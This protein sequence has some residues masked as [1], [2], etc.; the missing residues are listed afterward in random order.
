MNLLDVVPTVLDWFQLSYPRYSIFRKTPQTTLA[1]NS[2]MPLVQSG[3]SN[4]HSFD[5]TFAS[6]SLHEITMY[7]PMRVV[8]TQSHKLIQNINYLMPF[9]IDQDLYVSRTF[10]NMMKRTSSGQTL[11]WYKT[12]HSYYY[13]PQW[14]LFDLKTDPHEL[15]N[16]Y[17]MPAYENITIDLMQKLR[18]WQ[19]V[20]ADPWICAPDGVLENKGR[21]RHSPTCLP[22]Y[23][24][25]AVPSHD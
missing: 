16:L 24:G 1:G 17:G 2:L 18:T 14:E 19:N 5:V 12:L 22:L 7:Y 8:L 23:N 13:R 15:H 11:R 21:Y 9:P 20:T 3:G 25:I 10:M 6:Q 4:S